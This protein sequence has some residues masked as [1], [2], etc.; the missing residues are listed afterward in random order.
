MA[1]SDRRPYETAMLIT[2]VLLDACAD[3]LVFRLETIADIE[4]PSATIH[5]SDR[6]KYVGNTYYGSRIQ[7]PAIKRTIGEWLAPV[8]EFSTLQI[9]VSNVDG[10]YNPLM[11]GG[12]NWSGWVGKALEIKRGLFD[13][14]SSYTTV[15]KGYV[16]EV[17]GFSRDNKSLTVI[18]RDE[19][20]RLNADFPMAVWDQATYP[21]ISAAVAGTYIPVIY[22]D[23][24]VALDP[25]PAIVPAVVVNSGDPFLDWRDSNIEITVGAPGIVTAA[26]HCLDTD[27]PI[28][29]DTNGTLPSP[30]S[31]GGTYY[32]VVLDVDNFGLATLPGGLAIAMTGPQTGQHRF[33]PA[34]IGT[35]AAVQCVI[36]T[37]AL[38]ELQ[39]DQIYLKRS[40]GFYAVPISEIG[41]LVGTNNQ[42]TVTQNNLGVLW[43]GGK[44]FLYSSS[45]VFVVRCRGKNLGG[46]SDNIVA[47]AAD[48]LQTYGGAVAGDFH[49][50]W[51]T[52]M[53]KITP[54]QSAVA[55]FK[56]RVFE[57]EK[58]Q[59]MQFALS[60]LEQVRLEAFIDSNRKIKIN[61]MHFEDWPAAPSFSIQTWDAERDSFRPKLDDR[62]TFNRV[63]GDYNFSPLDKRN[64][65]QTGVLRNQAAI[66]QMGKEISKKIVFPNLYDEITVK[67]QCTEILRLASAQSELVEINVSPR[68]M[69]K[70]L[71][72]WVLINVSFGASIFENVP[73]MIR[74]IGQDQS[75]VK[76]IMKLWSMQLVPF[77]G[78]NPGYAGIVG[79]YAATITE[80]T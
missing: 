78:W 33:R 17:G 32:A 13:I 45:D 43:V 19:F 59:A 69:L 74:D 4:T 27:D 71:G 24:T 8:L 67:A 21:K 53:A 70:D 47:I 75:G 36:T 38:L 46:N 44:E 57:A 50:N 26:S 14:A 10:I 28:E 73:A 3:N 40:D 7:L 6:N 29:I 18:A 30:L 16:T 9:S 61:S 79:G 52:Y 22:G 31:P 76:I 39:T 23:W 56:A 20:D 68:A 2:Q 63:A 1:W 25:N 55:T 41:G 37:Q 72:D 34:A 60:L 35:R 42:F 62:N 77:P 54:A 66:T 11:P 15:F 49:A 65:R 12:I 80:E 58:Q 51:A 5:A 64:T 48:I